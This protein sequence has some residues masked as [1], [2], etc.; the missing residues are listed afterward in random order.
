M[1]HITTMHCEKCG[2]PMQEVDNPSL[3]GNLL[4]LKFQCMQCNHA[5]YK[6]TGVGT[7]IGVLALATGAVALIKGLGLDKSGDPDQ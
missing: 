4:K 3:V 1:T 5:V 6:E 7:A 2:N